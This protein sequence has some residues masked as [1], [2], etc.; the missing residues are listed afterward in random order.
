MRLKIGM[1][2]DTSG[3]LMNPATRLPDAMKIVY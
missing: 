1:I 3:A 2:P